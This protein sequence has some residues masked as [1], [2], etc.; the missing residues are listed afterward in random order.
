MVCAELAQHVWM[1]VDHVGRAS[2][3]QVARLWANV[4]LPQDLKALGVCQG[5]MPDAD[6][7]DLNNA[8]RQCCNKLTRFHLHCNVPT[9]PYVH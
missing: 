7:Y 2:L 8:P 1:G 6:L 5:V 4:A 9:N 3:Q